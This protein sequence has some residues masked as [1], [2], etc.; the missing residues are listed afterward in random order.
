MFN[1]VQL[2][3]IDSRIPEEVL[4]CISYS[5]KLYFN[6]MCSQTLDF[7]KAIIDSIDVLTLNKQYM[8]V[9]ERLKTQITDCIDCY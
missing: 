5:I 3:K 2:W 8:P 6:V 7:Y 9:S 4:K 1:K